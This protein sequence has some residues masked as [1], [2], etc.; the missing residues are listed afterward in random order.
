MA[1][2]YLEGM[3]RERAA[4]QR[5]SALTLSQHGGA[6][7]AV[8]HASLAIRMCAIRCLRARG[9]S[10]APPD[11]ASA[12]G[13]ARGSQAPAAAGFRPPRLEIPPYELTAALALGASSGSATRSRR[14]WSA[15]ASAIRPPR[16]RSWPPTRSTRRPRFAGHRRGRRARSS[17]RSPAAAGSPCTATTTSTASARRRSWSARC[18]RWAPTSTASCPTADDGYG[19]SARDR[20]AAGR[21]R[22]AT[23]G[24][25]RLRDHRRRGGRG[26]ARAAGIEVVVTDHHAPRADGRCRTRR[27][28]TRRC[29]ATRA[30]TCARPAVAY[31]LAQALSRRRARPRRL[32]A[33][34]RPGGAGDRRR[35]G[36]AARREPR[37][38]ARGPA[39]AGAHG[40]S[41]GCGR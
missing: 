28:C 15:A 10:T 7:W 22:H 35:R 33:R 14:C 25:R 12:A 24:H 41:P 8:R 27:S 37:A 32:D 29:A 34:P 23:A 2:V 5:P 40:A 16:A 1:L 17:R 30:R 19:L 26:R 9:S 3:R 13:P 6:A 39:R 20:R 36:A 31:K 11:R 38:G 18:A 4:Q 21:A